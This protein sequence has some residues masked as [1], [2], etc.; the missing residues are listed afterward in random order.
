M[1]RKKM[2]TEPKLKKLSEVSKVVDPIKLVEPGNAADGAHDGP[3]K[4]ETHHDD[5]L[6]H[7]QHVSEAPFAGKAEPRK[8]IPADWNDDGA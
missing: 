4:D 5:G 1:A 3:I 8:Y 6:D 2:F 7:H